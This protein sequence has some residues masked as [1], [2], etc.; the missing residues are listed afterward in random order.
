MVS[1]QT[2]SDTDVASVLVPETP[3]LPRVLI[4]GDSI[5]IGYASSVSELLRNKANIYRIIGNGCSTTNGL[6]KLSSWLDD[7]KWDVIHF[8][9]GLHDA[10]FRMGGKMQQVPPND[11]EANLRTMVRQLKAT[12][13][14]LIWATTTPA[15]EGDLG[16]DRKFDD[17]TTYNN[18]ALKIMQENAIEVNDLYT[19]VLPV[20]IEHR[21]PKDVHFTS[22]GYQFLAERVAESIATQLP[23]RDHQNT[24]TSAPQGQQKPEKS[25]S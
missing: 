22:A 5:S 24:A 4:I 9:F 1:A 21:K 2:H 6:A 11:Y 3:G 14:Q 16:N 18:I 15:P 7:G 17:V 20:V 23:Q 25:K 10:Q 13:A 19:A 8:N 12:G